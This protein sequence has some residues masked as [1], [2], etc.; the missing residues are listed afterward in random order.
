M[1]TPLLAAALIV[2]NEEK[3]LPACLGALNQLRPLLSEICVYDTGSSDRT[4]ETAEEAGARVER[5]YWDDDFSR[6]RNAAIAMTNS[7]WVLIVD[8]DEQVRA[9]QSSL[10]VHLRNGLTYGGLGYDAL[11]VLVAD[12]RGDGRTHQAFPSRRLLRPSRAEYRNQVH[13]DVYATGATALNEANL[14]ESVIALEHYGYVDAETVAAKTKRNEQIADHKLAFGAEG[15]E[16]LRALVDRARSRVGHGRIEEAL[17]D[18]RR[19]RAM[20]TARTYKTWGMEMFADL[21]VSQ[22]LYDEAADVISELRREGVSDAAYCDWLSSRLLAAKGDVSEAHAILSSID[23]LVTAIGS[24]VGTD[25]LL[26]ARMRTAL[27][28]KRNDEAAACLIRLMVGHGRIEPAY[29]ALL[30]KLWWP[31]P[32]EELALVLVESDRGFLTLLTER[33]G[34]AGQDGKRLAVLIAAQAQTG[35]ITHIASPQNGREKVLGNS[36]RKSD[37]RR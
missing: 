8:A 32:L 28:L 2:K 9:R 4:V 37:H 18:Y 35:A 5:G 36:F 6:A 12:V 10:A 17:A 14:P 23:R 11:T 13:E 27:R 31:L 21:L 30:I 25:T 3:A 15:E 16:M 1:E 34:S 22:G 19:V 33:L 7:K 20:A 29:P 26:Q 24:V